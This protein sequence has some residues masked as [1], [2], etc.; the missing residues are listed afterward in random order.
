MENLRRFIRQK[1]E[2][3][4]DQ[5]VAFGEEDFRW[6]DRVFGH[7][8]QTCEA[9]R[10]GCVR[11]TLLE[12]KNREQRDQEARHRLL[13]LMNE[14]KG[15]HRLGDIAVLTRGNQDVELITNW[16]LEAGWQVVSERTANIRN[17]AL[18]Q[19]VVAFLRFLKTPR[20][21]RAFAEVILGDL[22]GRASGLSVRERHDFVFTCRDLLTKQKGGALYIHFRQ[23]Y[24]DIWQ[25]L[26]G[27]FVRC[28]GWSPLYELVIS[29][30]ARWGC[31]DR[32]SEYQ[33]FLMHFLELIR[34]QEEEFLDIASFLSFF[35]R[36][37][38]EDLYV[39]LIAPDAVRVLTIHK[40][41]GLEFPVVVI[42]FLEMRVQVGSRGGDQTPA[43]VTRRR[44]GAMELWRIKKNY[45][46]LSPEADRIYAQEYKEAF[47]DELNNVYVALTRPRRELHAFIPPKAGN[48]VNLVPL[49]IPS[50]V[51]S[52]GDPVHEPSADISGPASARFLSLATYG[53]GMGYLREEFGSKEER[54][55]RPERLMGQAVHLV[56][57]Y[58]KDITEQD[59][60][61]ITKD[62]V[63]Q[64][65]GVMREALCWET[66]Q[67]KVE[68]FLRRPEVRPLFLVQGKDVRTE[69]PLV[70]ASGRERR[71]DRLIIEPDQVTV[72]EF[73]TGSD[74]DGAHQRQVEDYQA[75]LRRM[76]PDRRVVGRILY[77]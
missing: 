17:N 71:V 24:P 43:Y 36:M 12:A 39:P 21:N 51:F 2:R 40:A 68:A 46:L 52:L 20:D 67:G 54:N 32:F 1:Q 27:E 10:E 48:A 72:V 59:I 8:R 58:I 3:L 63:H 7:A 64:A 9:T 31:L 44:D 70:D 41:K 16:L 55:A 28:A 25:E 14:L 37:E 22:F 4:K 11:L 77:L 53:D 19:E 26:I 50:E 23:K 69:E 42:P 29:L 18:I 60:A 57:S 49:L 33:G 13:S 76:Y 15:R 30:Y 62:A 34:K 56:L 45:R 5:V 65:R 74:K 47:L 73:K 35:D 6:L 61:A 66:C 75:L 38:G